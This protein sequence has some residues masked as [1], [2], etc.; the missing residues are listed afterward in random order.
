M[1]TKQPKL[2]KLGAQVNLWRTKLDVLMAHAARASAQAKL[3]HQK[4]FDDSSAKPVPAESKLDAL[5]ES[6]IEKWM[7]LKAGVGSA[8]NDLDV[9]RRTQ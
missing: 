4:R 2:N 8:W 5:R 3:D 7:M 1:K 6:G 9:G